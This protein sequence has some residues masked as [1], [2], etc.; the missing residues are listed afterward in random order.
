M[1]P[2]ANIRVALGRDS[3]SHMQPGDFMELNSSL[4]GLAHTP[5]SR[6]AARLTRFAIITLLTL[7]TPG[8]L[9][10]QAGS[11]GGTVVG[12]V[13]SNPIPGA[14]IRVQGTTLGA[15]TDANGRFRI[16]GLSGESAVLEVRRIGFRMSTITV[17]VGEAGARI[18]LVEQSVALD[19][20]VVTGTAGGQALRELGN[21]VSMV[22]A[23]EATEKGTVNS[24]QQLLNGRVPGLIIIPS[25][26]NVGT[27]AR[28]RIRGAASLSLSNEPLIYVDGIRVN[29]S[30]STGPINQGFGSNSISRINDFN[31]DDIESVEV[32]KGPAAA[33]LYGTEASNGVI[34]IITKKGSSGKPRWTFSTRQGY[35]YLRD[36]EGRWPVNY[37]AIRR[38]G[39]P[40]A[41]VR[42]TVAIDLIELEKSRGNEI[43]QK[44]PL[45]E[46]DFS[47]GG[48]SDLFRYFAAAGLEDS[49]GIEASNTV[50]RRTG[51]L[52]LT[53]NVSPRL[54]FGINLS[55]SNGNITLPCEAGCG[56]RTLSSILANP[57]ND[58]VLSNGQPNPRRG[59]NSGLPEAYDAFY[60]FYQVTDRFTG[61]VTINQQP[62]S[63][64]KHRLTAG[65]DR[66]REENSELQR[67][68]TDSL[69]RAVLSVTGLGFRDMTF[70]TINNYTADYS[71][72]ALFDLSKTLKSTTSFGAQYYRNWF[73]I[74]C[75]FGSGFPSPDVTTVSATTTGRGT[76]HDIEED[77]TLGLYVQEQIG[78]ND[79][80]FLT[81]AIRAD[82]NSAFG[83]NFDRVYYPKFSVSWVLSEEPF[84][85]FGSIDA[86]KLRAAYGESGKQPITFSALQTYTSATGPGD[87]PTVTPLSIGNPDLGPE[88]SKEIELGF[89]LGAFRDRV[90]LEFSWYRKRT[91]DAIL[92][93]Q[94]APSIGIPG[95]QPFNAGSVKNWGTELMLRFRPVVRDRFE[96]E[97]AIGHSTND[98]E[99]EDLSTPNEIL[100][101]RRQA[102]CAGYVPGTTDP[103]SCRVQDFVL[104]S[105]GTLPP[106]HQVGYPIGSYFNKRIVSAELNSAGRATNI[107][108]DDDKGG[109]IACA[110]APFVFIGRTIPTSEGSFSNTF[111][112]FRNLRLSGLL[113]FKRGHYKIDGNYRF[114]CTVSLR[115]RE[116][117]YPAEFDPKL[118][119][120]IQAGGDG[121]PDAYI[122]EASFAKLRE[123]SMSYTLPMINT[124]LLNFSRAVVTLAGRNLATWTDYTGLEPEAFFLGGTRG[125][126]FS[127]FEQTT[128]PQTSQWILGIR[129]DW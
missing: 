12:G 25:T 127:Q 46:Y 48:G 17:R 118:I 28:I 51:R 115:C 53:S 50:K 104:G 117:F 87:V 3:H 65:T 27:G 103:S 84:W 88:R 7:A 95:T 71:A 33:T 57:A 85:S 98:S 82:D 119:A 1:E 126:S 93:R 97:A 70:R 10:A 76:C 113:D 23:A 47:T 35:T 112:L 4:A 74:S 37:G 121:L 63:W 102:T 34:Q 38:P 80:V 60:E 78:L 11:V 69:F 79:R 73:E 31:P 30:P 49:E 125:G 40:S 42:D 52:N 9:H 75:A 108:C 22:N 5:P 26:G 124:R 14:Q 91:I 105:T 67:R 92:D 15:I 86:L 116:N 109:A 94:I 19:E 110:S 54:D 129:L 32:I 72:S 128:N 58:T 18:P 44:G 111:T 120:S 62:S 21:A 59:Y 20:V 77:A 81:A 114:R 66:T 2:P 13:S 96:W 39:Q 106:R 45:R 16:G 89:D 123:L 41:A 107:M 101:L 64:F 43:F 100:E 122:K 83:K 61:G 56:G 36:P 6:S 24:F 90:G 55:Y 29:G 99:V 68:L 8:L